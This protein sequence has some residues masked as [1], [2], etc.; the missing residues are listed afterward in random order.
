M[1]L[2]NEDPLIS[3]RRAK[4]RGC[5][6]YIRMKRGYQRVRVYDMSEVSKAEMYEINFKIYRKMKT[7]YC[8]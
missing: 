3:G 2:Y 4:V 1:K 7:L 8:M 6:K 5:W